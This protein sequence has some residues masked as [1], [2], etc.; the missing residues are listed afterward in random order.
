MARKP[1]A[2]KTD[3]EIAF[4]QEPT[5][6]RT[7]AKQSYN[8]KMSIALTWYRN[9]I[10]DK[11]K[12]RWMVEW[13]IAN[14]KIDPKLLKNIP[15]YACGTYG[16]LA[17]MLDRGFKAKKKDIQKLRDWISAQAGLH[18]L[19]EADTKPKTAPRK[20]PRLVKEDK[21]A[22]FYTA[23]DLFIDHAT[24]D[25]A[26]P[27]G[28]L[29][30]SEWKELE[31]HYQRGLDDIEANPKDYSDPKGD[32]SSYRKV[33]ELIKQGAVVTKIT[34]V[35]KKKP[36]TKD[37]AVA[38]LNYLNDYPPLGLVS[39]N[40]EKLIGATIAVL[41]NTKYRKIQIYVSEGLSVKGSTLKDFDAEQS[42]SKTVRK[43]EE[44]LKTLTTAKKAVKLVSELKTARQD[45]TGRVNKDTII[46]K[47]W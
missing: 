30:T 25:L 28:T 24:N 14:T 29:N 4:G 19:A 35:R 3:D 37:K 44:F 11:D 26:L 40:P 2:R 47:V 17:R 9:V 41:F 7:S 38:K 31:D 43:P 12:K 6:A 46:L 36:V 5:W 34:R 23:M 39:L 22:P 45:V 32:A 15:D 8:S 18:S 33:L 20:A 42:Y 13:A 10:D 16:A 27:K 1:R 21:L